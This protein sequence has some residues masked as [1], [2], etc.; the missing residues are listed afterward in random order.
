MAAPA[1]PGISEARVPCP[2]C[3]GLIHPVAGRCKHCKEDLTSFRSGRPQ[4]AAVLPALMGNGKSNGHIVAPIPVAKE[5]SQP[6]LPP[7]ESMSMTAAQD[8]PSAWRRWPVVVMVLAAVAIVG[9]VVVMVWLPPSSGE[10]S[11]ALPPPPAPE[12]MQTNPLPP[13][14]LDQQLQPKKIDD[15]PWGPPPP[16]AQVQ[17]R[18]TPDP[19]D[20]FDTPHGA[21]TDPLAQAFGGE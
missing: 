16:H 9:A 21:T 4:A 6:I 7:R 17:P 13:D 15:D 1:R 3:G 19:I 5:A 10:H 2:L 8:R 20:P 12:H 11:R 18:Q 14:Q